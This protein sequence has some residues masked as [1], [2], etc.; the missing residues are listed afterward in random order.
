MSCEELG[1]AYEA[2]KY[3]NYQTRG[4]P[5]HC[6]KGVVNRC[7]GCNAGNG[8]RALHVRIALLP[9]LSPVELDAELATDFRIWRSRFAT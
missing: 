7:K 8:E 1:E 4:P 5:G 3:A 2:G 6:Y 9:R